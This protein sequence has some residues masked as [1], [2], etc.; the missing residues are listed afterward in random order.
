[1][2]KFLKYFV[3]AKHPNTVTWSMEILYLLTNR[4][5][6]D[7][8]KLEKKL[9][10]ELSEVFDSVL[11]SAASILTDSFGVNYTEEYGI[12]KICFSP[13]VY[14]MIKR[15]QFTKQRGELS[16][17]RRPYRSNIYLV[18]DERF[19]KE[20]EEIPLQKESI[21]AEIE[22]LRD[23][24]KQDNATEMSMFLKFLNNS[25]HQEECK[26]GPSMQQ[27][28]YKLFTVITL[29]QT[30]VR[31]TLSIFSTEETDKINLSL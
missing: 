7:D 31:L 22:Q 15:Y 29:R 24:E 17:D 13:S 6:P 12:D 14:E 8:S 25:L 20:H 21:F 19:V 3:N 11:K 5:K 9:K 4:F 16:A 28:F 18:F 2:N 1:M 26:I 27:E 23:F 10:L 30:L